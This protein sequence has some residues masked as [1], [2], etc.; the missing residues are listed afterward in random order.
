MAT[1][2]GSATIA[3]G[4]TTSNAIDL[5]TVNAWNGFLGFVMPA[6]F[7]GATISFQ[8]SLDD[9]TYQALNDSS[10]NAISITVTASKTYGFKADVRAALSPWRYIKIVSASAEGGSRT[11]PLLIK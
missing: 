2:A 4:A 8:V 1:L 11:I 3:S 7:T 9:V 10:N 5:G 6:A